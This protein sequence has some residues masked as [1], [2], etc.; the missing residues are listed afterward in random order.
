MKMKVRMFLIGLLLHGAV[1]G[2]VWYDSA[3]GITWNY[4]IVGGEACIHKGVEQS[5]IS[6]LSPRSVTVPSSLGGKQVTAIGD[7]AF[8]DCWAITTIKLPSSV[9]RIGYMAFA[10]CWGVTTITLPMNLREVGVDAFADCWGLGEIKVATGNLYY[11]SDDGILYNKSKTE[12]ICCPQTKCGSI[13][14]PSSVVKVGGSAFDNCCSITAVKFPVMLRTIGESSFS[15]CTSL[16]ELDLPDKVSAIGQSAFAFCTKLNSIHLPGNIKDIEKETFYSCSSLNSI[17]IPSGVTNIASSA[18]YG[19]DNVTVVAMPESIE[20]IGEDAFR[21]CSSLKDVSL[22]TNIVAIGSGAFAGCVKIEEIVIP[23]GLKRVEGMTFSNC[24]DLLTVRIPKTV[25]YIGL[26]AFGSCDKLC[27]VVVDFGDT[28]RVRRMIEFSG[29]DVTRLAFQELPLPPI[30]EPVVIHKVTFDLGEH[31]LRSGGGELVQYVTNTC[32]AVAPEIIVQDGWKFDGWSEDFSFVTNDVGVSA[33]YYATKPDGLYTETI[34]GVEWTY[35]IK[36]ECAIIGGGEKAIPAVSISTDC[37]LVVPDRLGGWPVVSVAD[38]A[39][40]TCNYIPSIVLPN[41][42]TNI[43]SSSFHSCFRLESLLIPNGVVEI[44]DSAFAGCENFVS[45]KLPSGL[46]VIRNYLFYGCRKLKVIEM[47]EGIESIGDYAFDG[48]D[49]IRKIYIPQSVKSIGECSLECLEEISVADGNA[50]FCVSNGVLYDKEKTTLY[51]CPSLSTDVRIPQGVRTVKNSAFQNCKNLQT[52]T[53]PDGV[54]NIEDS[55]FFGCGLE[56]MYLPCGVTNIGNYAFAE[57]SRLTALTVPSSVE[58]IGRGVL[59]CCSSIN[60]LELPF[61]GECRDVMRGQSAVLGYLF[62]YYESNA[63]WIDW[64]NHQTKQ[65]Y[66]PGRYLYAY[67]P[68]ALKHVTITDVATIRYG[69]FS[70]CAGLSSVA[71]SPCVTNIE[72]SAFSGCSQISAV[73]VDDL[74]SWCNIS[75]ASSSSNPLNGARL[76]VDGVEI[77]DLQVPSDVARIE[78]FAFYGCCSLNSVSVPQ[79]VKHVGRYAFGYCSS[80]TKLNIEPGVLEIDEGAFIG[81][82]GLIDFDGFVIVDNVLY[83]YI[84][85]GSVATKDVEIPWGVKKISVNA[86]PYSTLLESIYIPSSVENI[87]ELAFWRCQMLQ[88]IY[89]EKGDSS[90]VKDLFR[91]VDVGAE[92]SMLEFVEIEDSIPEIDETASADQVRLALLRRLQTGFILQV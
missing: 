49:E 39:F 58:R 80:I 1:S 84:E 87:G 18:F 10:R 63:I 61:V 69:A 92:I 73:Y 4:E 65:T 77:Q 47:P 51:L 79:N 78:D 14:I 85:S 20:Q 59:F 57:C 23:N 55:A 22:P 62:D 72:E 40:H 82:V 29:F 91:V 19:C 42:V 6:L 3:S 44:G 50:F 13:E 5:A 9:R 25:E 2:E 33:R 38:Y 74:S 48:C 45:I 36:N 56:N 35:E 27:K 54:K 26:A 7:Y 53:L 30:V 21:E 8:Y 11:C 17:I 76:F 34:D 75:F 46:T 24:G 86:F 88:R 16:T 28:S 90:R 32:S 71:I 41:T 81:C 66:S 43:G 31:G 15:G 67:I 83:D 37:A 52:I 64:D 89:T 12:V 60:N 68:T 70:G